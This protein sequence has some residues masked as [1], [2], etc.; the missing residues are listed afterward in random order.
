MARNKQVKKLELFKYN[1]DVDG[2]QTFNIDKALNENWDKIEE[3]LENVD[4]SQGV[5]SHNTDPGSHEDIRQEIQT[6]K[7]QVEGIDVS[8]ESVTGKP[9]T[10]P[11]ST[12]T[13]EFPVTSVAGRTGEVTLSKS[14]VG[15]DLVNNWG[16]TS[17]V[18]NASN[19][20]YA[21]ALGVKQAYDKAMESYNLGVVKYL[22][23]S[24]NVR[25]TIDSGQVSFG[26]VSKNRISKITLPFTKTNIS[27]RGVIRLKLSTTVKGTGKNNST[28][29]PRDLDSITGGV[30][31]GSAFVLMDEPTNL[32]KLGQKSICD[33]EKGANLPKTR[34]YESHAPSAISEMDSFRKSQSLSAN[35]NGEVNL[36]YNETYDI[37][38]FNEPL[39]IV[40]HVELYTG[41]NDT[42]LLNANVQT[43]VQV[44]YDEIS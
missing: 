21:T 30:L 32:E 3:A 18:N 16:A 26:D 43:V 4:I 12:H 2:D 41:N 33:L 5:E 15:L 24:N 34:D 28:S 7:E 36:S 17:E 40:L 25:Q 22:K 23:P 38:L 19:T 42:T 9:E 20:T 39:F 27:G 35:Y 13:H 1:P 6:V 44:C 37:P 31:L 8:W 29:S 10:F 14:D 11:P